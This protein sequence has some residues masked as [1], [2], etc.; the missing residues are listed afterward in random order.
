MIHCSRPKRIAVCFSGLMRTYR[1][2]YQ[3]FVDT[4][5]E[6]NKENIVDVF[7]STWPTELS[8]NSMERMRRLSW[9]GE[10]IKPFEEEIIDFSDIYDKYKPKA[11][12]IESPI[13]FPSEWYTPTPGVHIQSLLSMTYK[14][15]TCDLLRRQ[16]ETVMGF[17]YD[18]T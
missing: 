13:I 9:Y 5:L 15:Y 1:Q 17:K 10:G 2:T 12:Q 16:Y 4:I 11:I 8:N 3:N 14:I 7:I 6:A 18:A